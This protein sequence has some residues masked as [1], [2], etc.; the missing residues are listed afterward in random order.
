MTVVHF[1]DIMI[2]N[3]KMAFRF[4]LGGIWDY[5]IW[6]LQ[7]NK[8]VHIQDKSGVRGI[9]RWISMEQTK[10][11]VIVAIICSNVIINLAP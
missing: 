10:Q 8:G 5:R 2:G 11:N 6:A 4:H 9:D 7:P 1:F 3:G